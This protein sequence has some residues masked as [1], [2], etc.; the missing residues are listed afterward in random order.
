MKHKYIAA[1]LFALAL[2][3]TAIAADDTTPRPGSQPPAPAADQMQFSGPITEVSREDKSITINDTKK[4]KHKLF[5]SEKTK[6][7]RGANDATWDDLKVG[8]TVEGFCRGD[9]ETAQADRLT[10]KE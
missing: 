7:M 5:I 3:L 6:L 8:A 9:K 2:P 4:G 10:I 1:I